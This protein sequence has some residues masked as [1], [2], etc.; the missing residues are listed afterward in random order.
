MMTP[1]DAGTILG[2]SLAAAAAQTVVADRW[3][4]LEGVMA[5]WAAGFA[6]FFALM[7]SPL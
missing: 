7:G 4:E 3:G 1:G 5:G 6:V 2:A